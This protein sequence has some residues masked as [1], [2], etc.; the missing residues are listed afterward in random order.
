MEMA[1]VIL[2]QMLVMALYMTAGYI[3][4]KKGKLTLEGSRILANLLVWLIVPA[5][6]IRAFCV[7]CTAEKLSMLGQSFILA[8]VA[9]L[10]TIGFASLFFRKNGVE[11]FAVAFSNAGFIG[12]PLVTSAL[13]EYAVFYICGMLVFV[14][15]L[16]WG[17]GV[18]TIKGERMSFSLRSFIANPFIIASIIGIFLFLTGLGT[19]LPGVVNTAIKG[20]ADLNA[21]LAMM[22]LGVYLAR[23]KLSELFT[24]KRL[25]FISVMRMWV[26]PVITMLLFCLFP[27][28]NEI[29]IAVLITASS[30]VGAN[31]AVYAQMFD[32]DYPYA[33][34]MVTCSTLLSIVMMPLFIALATLVFG[35]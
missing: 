18:P 24:T 15:C 19:K 30:P 4:F 3:L 10:F 28:A 32:G 23:T 9:M 25:Y 16:Q 27:I 31:V 14:N 6:L 35:M 2:K 12:I 7:E 21:P 26:I 11:C 22:V 5:M 13:G 34:Q 20:V 29:R 17:W 8:A 1:F 33:C